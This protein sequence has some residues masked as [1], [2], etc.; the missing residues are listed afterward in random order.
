MPNYANL[1]QWGGREAE[2]T[3]GYKVNLQITSQDQAVQQCKD[4]A[5]H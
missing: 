2:D 5:R 3:D 4:K 1:Q